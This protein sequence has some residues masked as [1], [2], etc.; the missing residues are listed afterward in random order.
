M[1][2]LKFILP[3]ISVFTIGYFL[4]VKSSIHPG[5]Q[6]AQAQNPDG[7]YEING[8]ST[9]LGEYY[10]RGWVH[11][12][13]VQRLIKWKTYSYQGNAVESV[14][15]G[16]VTANSFDFSLSLSN[17]ITRFENFNAEKIDLVPITLS[18]PLESLSGEFSLVVKGD[19]E[20]KETWTRTKEAGNTP[21]W[22][23]LR[24]SVVGNGDKHPLITVIGK[25][26]GI[27]K[28]I[29]MYRNLPEIKQYE[30]NPVFKNADQVWIQDKTDAD[31]YLKNP[32]ILRVTNKTI[33]PLSLAE[34]VMRKNAYGHTLAFKADYLGRET[35]NLNLN[36]GGMLE[37]AILDDNGNKINQAPEGDSAL[38][39]AMYG[40]SQVIRFQLTKDPEAMANF[41]KVL[42]GTLT[43]LEIPNDT[44]QFARSVAISPATE[45]MGKEWVQGTGKFSHLKWL[46]G[47]NNDMSK[48]HFITLS[49]A[50]KMIGNNE[51]E[52]IQRIQKDVKNLATP[53]T[54]KERGFNYGIANGID[55]LWN[56]NE[57]SLKVFHKQLI[58]IESFL[59][60]FTHLDAGIYIG[61]IADWSG[62]HLTMTSIMSQYFVSE[63]LA[64]VFPD[65]NK[66]KKIHAS[67]QASLIEIDKV[68]K[69]AHRNFLTIM[70]YN[71]SAKARQDSEYA[72]R[73]K[74]AVWALKEVPAPRFTG[75]AA[76]EFAKRSDWSVSAWPRQPWKAMQGFRK[77]KDDPN[78]ISLIQGAYAYPYF[79]GTAWS[80]TYFWKDIPFPTY[81]GSNKHT[82]S[83]SS[84][85]L[86]LY[87]V[88]RSS[89]LITE[90][91]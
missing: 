89:G 58:N 23:D 69:N 16:K 54:I 76:A 1:K 4:I 40:W 12:G 17:V 29:E 52:L 61:G 86:M 73:A 11:N 56:K 24:Q 13:V 38:W 85:Y 9:K 84:D 2:K 44:N 77:L 64:K 5:R 28:V 78:V 10:G 43:L 66:T 19:G 53:T 68:Y 55:A 49:L 39:T 79:E 59:S 88:S 18:M 65:D 8:R 26:A 36:A 72:K 41:K 75:N 30:S 34:A 51:V 32:N 83:F 81:F 7:D 50:H 3:L 71:Y 20:L 70:A 45:S 42:M 74:E 15:S 57:E 46:K 63:E 91:D 25:I 31:F 47:G 14:W 6:I 80:T 60:H 82:K 22:E 67:A 87:W 35:L 62:I 33:N 90:Q 48:G 27:N 21:L 37:V